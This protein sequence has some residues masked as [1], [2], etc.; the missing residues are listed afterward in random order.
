MEILH[1]NESNG[2]ES[3]QLVERMDSAIGDA[4]ASIGM[5]MSELVRRSLRGGVG[6]I[7]ATIQDYAHTQVGSAID[8]MMPEITQTVEKLAETTSTRVTEVAVGRIGED[9]KAVETRTVE[10]TQVFA[11]RIKA[12]SEAALEIV[13][14][15]IGESRDTSQ[16]TARDLKDL[17]TR[18]KESWKKVQA[19]LQNANELRSQLEQRLGETQ[20]DLSRSVQQVSEML[21]HQEKTR[22]ELTVASQ[23]LSETR[24]V[25]KGSQQELAQTQQTL[26]E[27][28]NDL[29]ELRTLA[30]QK[31][32][33]LESVC[34][35]LEKRLQELE[36]PRG[37]RALFSKMKGD[38]KK[39]PSNEDEA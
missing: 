27:A 30:A 23:Q 11:A 37:L 2:V 24:R 28:L 7:G 22:E 32:N 18:A 1:R 17:Q 19:E 4:S 5:I 26:S 39:S 25:L 33:R 13:H 14:R 9:L 35:G 16:S 3:S 12:D 36:R 15:A 38:G 29:K 6:D 34:S 21:R 10:H 8:K 31:T 20:A